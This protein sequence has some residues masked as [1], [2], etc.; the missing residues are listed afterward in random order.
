MPHVF[1]TV[2]NALFAIPSLNFNFTDFYPVRFD[3][4]A[5]WVRLLPDGISARH[6]R[7]QYRK[8][9]R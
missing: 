5:G 3:S 4:L 8:I 9:L 2:I 6:M 7:L 1:I